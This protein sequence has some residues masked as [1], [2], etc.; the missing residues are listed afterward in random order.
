[1]IPKIP[2]AESVVRWFGSW[3]S[4]HDAEVLSVLIDRDGPSRLRLRT[5]ITGDETD[6]KGYFIRQH[7]VVVVF[8]FKRI[9]H[10]RLEGEDADRQNVIAGLV[11]DEIAGGYRLELLPCY[12]VAGEIR[13]K[14]VLVRLES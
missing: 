2:G 12:G 8:E 6:G 9:N 13:A 3:P 1:M 10:I 11:V 4:F 5:W 7:E 14:E